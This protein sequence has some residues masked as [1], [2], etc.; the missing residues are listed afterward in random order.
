VA[1]NPSFAEAHY[2]LGLTYYEKKNYS[3]AK[4]HVERARQLGYN[5]SSKIAELIDQAP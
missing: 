3:L 5:V 1:I 2:K 4:T